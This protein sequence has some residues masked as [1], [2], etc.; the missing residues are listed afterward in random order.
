M[1]VIYIPQDLRQAAIGT[2]LGQIAGAF[3]QNYID[4][5]KMQA[6][7]DAA[8]GNTDTS[9]SSS[10]DQQN[11]STPNARPKDSGAQADPSYAMM[12]GQQIGGKPP[13]EITDPKQAGY[14]T[15]EMLAAG[16]DAGKE[17][18]GKIAIIQADG[19]S[20]PVLPPPPT[21]PNMAAMVSAADGNPKALARA[22][23]IVQNY[24]IQRQQ[25]EDQRRD[26]QFEQ[27]MRQGERRL[28][29]SYNNFLNKIQQQD[30]TNKRED[31]KLGL[32]EE[33]N[34]REATLFPLTVAKNKVA[35][36]KDATQLK[37]LQ[38]EQSTLW[39]PKEIQTMAEQY[40]SRGFENPP[41]FGLGRG[42]AAVNR[43]NFW[44]AVANL[45]MNSEQRREATLAMHMDKS[46]VAA[47]GRQLQ[48]LNVQINKSDQ[49][50]QPIQQ[51]FEKLKP[52]LGNATMWNRFKKAVLTGTGDPAFSR[53]DVYVNSFLQAYAKAQNP[54]GLST[55]E[56]R[57]TVSQYLDT[58]SSFPQ[59]QAK[60]EAIRVDLQKD[61]AATVAGASEAVHGI[62]RLGVFGTEE[63]NSGGPTGSGT[64]AA[65]GGGSNDPL[66]ILNQ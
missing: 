9:V 10:S 64:G 4:K 21:P 52:I 24:S 60:M 56:L 13:K 14:V 39:N 53:A 2:G 17:A 58:V 28:Q 36:A 11:A 18:A 50:Y 54:N 20:V 42:A 6:V 43:N 38:Q 27:T 44:R 19:M 22:K 15:P 23:A 47:G 30:K 55:D 63:G 46:A 57:K 65:T 5:N 49:L 25:W 7:N 29:L 45:P 59:L 35:I 51:E 12:E 48:N 37:Q 62:S 66:G 31:V 34:A 41:T 8:Y 61:K 26:V 33:K 40:A 3:I 32:A 1:A 16:Q